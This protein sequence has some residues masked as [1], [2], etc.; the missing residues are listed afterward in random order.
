MQTNIVI[1][2]TGRL[3]TQII[4]AFNENNGFSCFIYGRDKKKVDALLEQYSCLTSISLDQISS[5]S[6]CLLCVSDSVLKEVADSIAEK[7][8]VLI[9]FS[10]AQSLDSLLISHANGAVYW[11]LKSFSFE[12]ESNWENTPVAV[13]VSTKKSEEAIKQINSYLK[14]RLFYLDEDQ[15][16]KLHLAAVL[17]NNFSNHLFHLAYDWCIQNQLPFESLIPIIQQTANRINSQDPAQ[18]QTGPAARKDEKTIASHEM[19]LQNNAQLKEIYTLFT[20]LIK[21]TSN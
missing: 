17:V 9:H 19:L 10:G 5:V 8:C 13:Q 7:N 11:P 16:M 12:E 18:F 20:A 2:G 3:A 21:S 14:A 15:R 4:K 1:I 6:I